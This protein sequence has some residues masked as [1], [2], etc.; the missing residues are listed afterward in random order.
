MRMWRIFLTSVAM[1]TGACSLIGGLP[2]MTLARYTYRA[3]R[4]ETENGLPQNFVVATAQTPDGYL[5]VGMLGGVAKFN[6]Q[7]FLPFG[8]LD[9]ST[10]FLR[11]MFVTKAG[12]LWLGTYKGVMIAKEAGLDPWSGNKD[13]ASQDVRC[14]A[15]TPDGTMWVGTANQLVRHH[16]GVSE[17]VYPNS[18]WPKLRGAYTLLPDGEAGVLVGTSRGLFRISGQSIAKIKLPAALDNANI[19]SLARAPDGTLWVGSAGAGLARLDPQGGCDVFTADDGLPSDHVRTL[20]VDRAGRLWSGT[21]RGLAVFDGKKFVTPEVPDMPLDYDIVSLRQ[22]IEG[23][24]WVGGIRGLLRL[25]AGRFTMLDHSIGIGNRALLCAKEFSDGS[26]WVGLSNGGVVRVQNGEYDTYRLSSGTQRTSDTILSLAE[27]EPG[28]ALVGSYAGLYWIKD[29]KAEKAPTPLRYS[30]EVRVLHRDAQGTLWYG[31]LE[32]GLMKVE[33]QE[34]KT[35]SLK[36]GM[37]SNDV[38]C[39]ID[40]GSGGLWVGTAGGLVSV[41]GQ[42]IRSWNA[43]DGLPAPSVRALYLDKKHVLWVGTDRGLARFKDGRFASWTKADGLF[44][45]DIRQ[46]VEDD[47]GYLWLTSPMGLFRMRKQDLESSAAGERRLLGCMRFGSSWGVASCENFT[48]SNPTAWKLRDG[49]MIFTTVSGLLVADPSAID[50]NLR[51]PPVV[52]DQVRFRNVPVAL[53]NNTIAIG[54]A[55]GSLEIDFAGLSYCDPSRTV[56]R[57]KMEGVDADWVETSARRTVTYH[58]LQ[59]GSYTFRVL[60]CN[61]DGVWNETGLGLQVR[62]LPHYYETAWFRTGSVFLGLLIFYGLYRWRSNYIRCRSAEL[63]RAVEERTRSLKSE[64]AR[65]ELAQS[66]LLLSEKQFAKIVSSSPMPLA[67]IDLSDGRF[68]EVNPSFCEYFGKQADAV[69]SSTDREIPLWPSPEVRAEVYKDVQARRRVLNRECTIRVDG[70][71]RQVL[72]SAEPISLKT[73]PHM[74]LILLDIS[75]RIALEQQVRQLQKIEATGQLAAG[76]AHDFNNLLTVI[77]GQLC[78]MK[79]D[80][81]NR[82]AEDADSL[83]QAL[84]AAE[85]A[86]TLTR[87]LLMFSR[88]HRIEPKAFRICDLVRRLTKIIQ[89]V[90]GETIELLSELEPELPMVDGDEVQLEQVL[91]NIAMNARDAMPKGGRFKLIVSTKQFSAEDASRNPEARVG[92]FVQIEAQD[93]GCGMPPEVLERVFEP[94]FTTKEPGRGTGLGLSMAYGTVHQ[95][96][97]WIEIQSEVGRGTSMKI[98][99]PALDVPVTRGTTPPMPA[100]RK[101]GSVCILYVEDEESVRTMVK[102]ALEGRGYRVLSAADAHGAIEIWQ[103]QWANI[104]LVFSDIVMPG[105]ITGIELVMQLKREKSDL[106]VLLTTGYSADALNLKLDPEIQILSKPYTIDF[107]TQAIERTLAR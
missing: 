92:R 103:E 74:L 12:T 93:S 15:E 75:E 62:V 50:M 4:W 77:I 60:A 81:P 98:F 94:F 8:D 10:P 97:G 17:V 19:V 27:F 29:G 82:S 89:P 71:S 102:R 67:L 99:L 5:W 40:D 91:V 22:D 34:I 51:P 20:L 13:L 9:E 96:G 87:Q 73:G 100:E 72:I 64:M 33:G 46:I 47:F 61:N 18:S 49:R 35:F 39:I 42:K 86:A 1:W 104:S 38:R 41:Q 66:E 105:G 30:K 52:V 69:C 70:R 31:S 21:M 63:E 95:H 7:R 68:T 11:C 28:V 25:D 88:K 83:E 23:N 57:Y 44:S 107:L 65:R 26:I 53:S 2:E 32:D 54:P 55:E 45:H 36:E 76:I 48:P 101:P 84:K 3:E 90:M 59:N 24:L 6:G 85:R 58:N 37:P 56:F 78:M 79:E 106:R 80:V 14:L 43:K 16:Q